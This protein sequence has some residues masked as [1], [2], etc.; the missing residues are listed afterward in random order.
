V[1]LGEPRNKTRRSVASIQLNGRAGIAVQ[2]AS[3]RLTTA[4]ATKLVA[5]SDNANH[6]LQSTLTLNMSAGVTY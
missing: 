6:T 3:T 5:C 1:S 4:P 2:E